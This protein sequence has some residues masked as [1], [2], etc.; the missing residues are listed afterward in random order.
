MNVQHCNKAYNKSTTK[1]RANVVQYI[2]WVT[3]KEC[4]YD[5]K[6]CDEL[7]QPRQKDREG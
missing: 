3:M 6:L 2:Q 7:N 1:S 5:K 4:L